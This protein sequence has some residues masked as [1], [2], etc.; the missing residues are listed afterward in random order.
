MNTSDFTKQCKYSNV[1]EYTSIHI[2]LNFRSNKVKL[3]LEYLIQLYITSTYA[4]FSPAGDIQQI[5]KCGYVVDNLV[6]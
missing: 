3:S 1:A 5:P 2:I 6:L 4:L